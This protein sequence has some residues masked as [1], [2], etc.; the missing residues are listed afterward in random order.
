MTALDVSEIRKEVRSGVR[1]V[2]GWAAGSWISA[3]RNLSNA[4]PF[5]AV[6][7][8][9]DLIEMEFAEEADPVF[10]YDRVGN[11]LYEWPENYMPSVQEVREICGQFI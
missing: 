8:G 7:R 11:L 1:Q 6:N 2:P 4:L 5:A 10:L 9:L 3:T